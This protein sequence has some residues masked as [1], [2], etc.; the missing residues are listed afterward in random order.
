MTSPRFDITA[1]HPEFLRLRSAAGAG[2]WAGIDQFFASLPDGNAAAEATWIVADIVGVEEFLRRVP[3]SRLSR[4][5]LA[6]RHIAQ[7]WAIRSS[8]RSQHV[9]SQQFAGMH[10]ALREEFAAITVQDMQ[11]VAQEAMSTGLLQV[12]EGLAADWAGFVQAPLFSTMAVHG[13]GHASRQYKGRSLVLGGEGVSLVTGAGTVTVLF[14]DCVA[15]RCWPDGARQ[16]FGADG[17]NISVE[18]TMYEMPPTAIGWLDAQVRP[19]ARI[20][21]PARASVPQPTAQSVAAVAAPRRTRS[22]MNRIGMVL[23]GLAAAFRAAGRLRDGVAG[24]RRPVGHGAGRGDHPVGAGRGDGRP[25]RAAVLPGTAGMTA[26]ARRGTDSTA[27]PVTR[28]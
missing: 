27:C 20:P 24:H 6:C 17:F 8:K 13:N 5:L 28:P 25:V 4:L 23:F 1:A 18:P 2:D 9:S 12:P 16:L 19:E 10:E 22:V 21:M 11:A 15:M 7:A 26:G 3:P 14:R